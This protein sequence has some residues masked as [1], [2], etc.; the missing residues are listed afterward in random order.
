MS[1]GKKILA[2]IFFWIVKIMIWSYWH[3]RICCQIWSRSRFSIIFEQIKMLCFFWNFEKLRKIY[4]KKKGIIFQ[5]YFFYKR[6][7]IFFS[8]WEKYFSDASKMSLVAELALLCIIIA[9][10]SV[11]GTFIGCKNSN[12]FQKK[13]A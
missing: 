10:F 9:K 13:M 6:F 3:I 1:V 5:V 8:T 11:V 4:G 2:F 12:N 7:Q